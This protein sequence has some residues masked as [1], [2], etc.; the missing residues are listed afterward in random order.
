MPLVSFQKIFWLT[1]SKDFYVD[2][3]TGLDYNEGTKSMKRSNKVFGDYKAEGRQL[4]PKEIKM[5]L[6]KFKQIK[7]ARRFSGKAI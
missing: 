5:V 1:L 6:M 3:R 2:V 7:M 4:M